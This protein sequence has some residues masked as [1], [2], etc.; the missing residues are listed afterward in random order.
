MKN[1]IWHLVI[2]VFIPVF[3]FVAIL[4]NRTRK[5]FIWGG[6]PLLNNKYWSNALREHGWPSI[7]LMEYYFD[8]NKKDDFDYYV[9]DFAPKLLPR[10]ARLGLG[11]CL[12]IIFTLRKAKVVHISF[13]GFLL[14]N[15]S[16]WRIEYFLFRLAGVKVI[17]IPFGADV[18][19]YSKLID[20]SLRYGLLASYPKYGRSEAQVEK[21]VKY[22]TKY[23]D[24]V[25]AGL[26][27]DG[28][29][30]WDVT[31]NQVFAIDIKSWKCKKEYSNNDGVNGPVKIIH[32]PNH[33]DFK[34]TEFLIDAVKK[35][36]QEGLLVELI[37]LEKVPNEKVRETMQT[38]D[39]LAEQFIFTGYALSG[40]EG[41]AS[42]LPVLANLDHE[43]YT[44][45]FR[46]Y[47]FLNECPILSSSPETLIDNLRILVRNPSLRT[48]LGHAGRKYVEKYHSSDTMHYLFGS[49]YDK[50]LYGK[51]V[52]LINLFHPLKSDYNKRKPYVQHPLVNSKLPND[53][54]VQL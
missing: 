53:Y 18:Y 42:G 45:V 6:A 54:P 28:L 13:N 52:D 4:P 8:I 34:G 25:V 22:W 11:T 5:Y 40:V 29:G 19:M 30:R 48:E 35:L 31:T 7:T 33:T 15:T 27:I 51:D 37:L 36:K 12:A 46:R 21:Y 24:T 49:I 38:V 16:F 17:V 39:I 43:A 44:T 2:A 1:F 20:P 41:M 32:T 3:F 23:A 14:G 26:I 47:A 10:V 9:D 50:I